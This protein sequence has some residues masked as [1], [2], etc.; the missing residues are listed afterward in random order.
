MFL[1]K[2]RSIWKNLKSFF[3][4]VDRLLLFLKREEFIGYINFTLA[5]G[6]SAIFLQEGDAVAGIKELNQERKTGPDALKEILAQAR[7]EDNESINVVELPYKKVAMM[8]EAFG[9][10]CHSI[11]KDL[12][13]EFSSLKRVITKLENDKFTGF[14]E[15]RFQKENKEAILLLEQGKVKGIFADE[16]QVGLDKESDIALRLITS[17]TVEEVENSGASFDIFARD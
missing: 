7:R 13:S 8:E 14:I 6:Q 1:P 17:K 9:F 3:V 10:G 16:I 12:S 11:Y 15:I 4:D 2:G 5:G